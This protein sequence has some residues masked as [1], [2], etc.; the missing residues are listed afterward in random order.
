MD[1]ETKFAKIEADAVAEDGTIS[2]YA[3][4]FGMKDHG[5]DIVV[6]GAFAKSLTERRPLMLWSHDL[7]QPI[8]M[9]TKSEEDAVGLR[10]EGKLAL[11]TAK[12][13]EAYDLLKMGAINGMSIGYKAIKTGREGAAR[14]LKEVALFEVSITPLP[15]LDSATIDAV[16]SVDDII[17]ATKSGDF[18]PLKRAVE[19]ALRDAGFPAWLAKAQAAL[20]PQ[21]LGDG[22]RDASASEIA[23]LIKEKFSFL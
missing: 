17:S 7:Q 10:V 12:G 23:K 22:S 5:G 1:L 2:G 13:R 20:A 3:S 14:L 16:K 11:T 15:M 18:A 9:W 6:A 8:G 4:R 21:A 19:G